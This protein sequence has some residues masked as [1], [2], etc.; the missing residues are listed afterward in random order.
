M[1]ES[2]NNYAKWKKYIFKYLLYDSMYGKFYKMQAYSDWKKISNCL[3][4]R[5]GKIT[6][7]CEKNCRGDEYI[8][9]LDCGDGFTVVYMCQNLE[10]RTL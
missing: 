10:N 4:G 1:N 9:Y 6:K 8:H 7:D 5:K 3:R 2:Q